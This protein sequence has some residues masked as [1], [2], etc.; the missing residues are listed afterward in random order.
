MVNTQVRASRPLP[1]ELTSSRK[2]DAQRVLRGS[3]SE[4]GGSPRTERPA[5]GGQLARGGGRFPGRGEAE[6]MPGGRP[7]V[8][9]GQVWEK[10]ACHCTCGTADS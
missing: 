7:S 4:P 10:A 2:T 3:N 8:G 9:K 1:W 5:V 6:S